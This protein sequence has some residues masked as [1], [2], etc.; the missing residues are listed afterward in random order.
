MDANDMGKA[1]T[2]VFDRSGF[3]NYGY[4]ETTSTIVAGKI[5]QAVSFNGTSNYINLYNPSSLQPA[6]ITVASW[7]KTTGNTGVIIRKGAG[8]YALEIGDGNGICSGANGKI[9][10]WIYNGTTYYCA[11]S[12]A[13]YNDNQWHQATG[14][15]D[16]SSVKIYVD[17]VL[18]TTTNITT[19]ISYS[20]GGIF[21]G[22]DSGG[23]IYWN[24]SLD[25]ARI[26]NYALSAQEVA[27]LYN[28]ARVNYK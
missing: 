1:T 10:F 12:S 2:T 18:I 20:A 26:Y 7:F 5:R 3:G 14:S 15:F 23:S 27:N 13:T 8:G 9:E 16:G 4:G 6:N 19:S 25:D 21:I 22:R 11:V 24:G 28:S 17:G